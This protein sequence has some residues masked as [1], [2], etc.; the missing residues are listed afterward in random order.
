MLENFD[1]WKSLFLQQEKYKNKKQIISMY[2]LV[3]S[4]THF[5]VAVQRLWP[6]FFISVDMRL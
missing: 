3:A 5:S 1:N 6:F 2:T 4:H